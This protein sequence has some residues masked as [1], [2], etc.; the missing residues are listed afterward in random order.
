MVQSLFMFFL[1]EKALRFHYGKGSIIEESGY[2]D[3]CF[4]SEWH[5]GAMLG[6]AASEQ[7][8]PWL[9]MWDLQFRI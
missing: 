3:F 6:V 8:G 7:A 9:D 5:C 1:K 2:L 4:A